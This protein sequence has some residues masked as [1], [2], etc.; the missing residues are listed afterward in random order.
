MAN[1]FD[2]GN[3]FSTFVRRVELQAH[4]CR[5][6]EEQSNAR[7]EAMAFALRNKVD[8]RLTMN[9]VNTDIDHQKLNRK[10]SEA[11]SLSEPGKSSG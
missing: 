10:L 2:T 6:D 8:V 9:G 3:L 7:I 5:T 4:V 1:A 11:C